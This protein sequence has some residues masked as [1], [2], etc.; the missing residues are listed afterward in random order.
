MMI[1][2]AQH[3]APTPLVDLAF[4]A[5]ATPVVSSAAIA[6]AFPTDP[7]VCWTSNDLTLAGVGVARELR[8][9]G[10]ARWQELIAASRLAS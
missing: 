6:A 1:A 9:H 8:G 4:Y 2:A 7:L 5:F 3:I 10:A